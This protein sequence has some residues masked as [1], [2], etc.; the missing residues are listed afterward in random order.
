VPHASPQTNNYSFGQLPDL[1]ADFGPAIG[2][3]GVE[4][5]LVVSGRARISTCIAVAPRLP[6]TLVDN[7]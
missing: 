3:D 6:R 7:Q 4:G 1:P 5:L 2:Q